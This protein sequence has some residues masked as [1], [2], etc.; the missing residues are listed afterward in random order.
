M[1][2][3]SL[4]FAGAVGAARFGAR[5]TAGLLA[6]AAV[7]RATF[8]GSL[9]GLPASFA[10]EAAEYAV[11]GRTPTKSRDGFDIATF[12]AGCFWGVEIDF[13]RVPGVIAT[14]SGYVQGRVEAPTYEEV[15]AGRSGHTE[16]VQLIY[17]PAVVSYEAL[18]AKFW[19]RLGRDATSYQLV[20]NDRGPQYR[21][22]IYTVTSDQ[23]ETARKSLV[24]QQAKHK[25]QIQTEV[26]AMRGFFWPAEEYHQQYLE[27]GGRFNSPQSAAKGDTTPIRC[28]G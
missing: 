20:G 15:S 10:K 9:T 28:Y 21:A 2:R 19:D 17:D 16:A 6:T 8:Y 7:A 4:G 27:K 13:Q 14:C 3:L 26:E 22:G 11:A 1:L 23:L 24:A 25:E 18:C 12:A 5:G